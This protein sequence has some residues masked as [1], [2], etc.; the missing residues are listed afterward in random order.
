MEF[1]TRQALRNRIREIVEPLVEGAGCELIGVELS[2]DQGGPI[3]RL[4]IDRPGGV[5][6]ADCTR[7]SRIVSPELDVEDPL[8]V[9]YRLEVSS[10]GMERPV[11]RPADFERF[12]GYRARV[13]MA[14]DWGRKRFTG[15]LRGLRDGQVVLEAEGQEHLLP[16]D[17]VDRLRLDLTP[18]EFDRLGDP[19]SE[20]PFDGSAEP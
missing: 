2:G 1:E 19:L 3:L 11:E 5:V 12:K 10:P 20:P 4:Y 9:A 15:I 7:V 8:P 13:R 16:L 6:V 18:E 17:R 14:P